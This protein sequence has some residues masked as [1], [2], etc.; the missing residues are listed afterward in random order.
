MSVVDFLTKKWLNNTPWV[1]DC[2]RL[3]HL[4]TTTVCLDGLYLQQGDWTK[5]TGH[6][7]FI[8]IFALVAGQVTVH[9]A[10]TAI[11][12]RKTQ[13]KWLI[14]SEFQMPMNN[15][16]APPVTRERIGWFNRTHII[17]YS[18]DLNKMAKYA[19]HLFILSLICL[20]SLVI[21]QLLSS[22]GHFW[23]FSTKS[24]DI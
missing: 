13:I 18:Q 20:C 3:N 2:F 23:R 9:L 24:N 11:S 7:M 10:P 21:Y 8:W 4:D 12:L 1:V 22:S 5:W 15:M 16:P 14:F 6:W 17:P 19:S